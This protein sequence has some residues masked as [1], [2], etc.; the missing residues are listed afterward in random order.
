MAR[1]RIARSMEKRK[2]A[3]KKKGGRTW[4]R[5]GYLYPF[6]LYGPTIVVGTGPTGPTGPT[7][8]VVQVVEL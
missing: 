3:G 4:G 7:G 2:L 5:G 1:L 6:I 8:H